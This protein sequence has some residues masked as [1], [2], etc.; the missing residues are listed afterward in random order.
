M[1]HVRRTPGGGLTKLP[2]FSYSL[3]M[4]NSSCAILAALLGASVVQAAD[5]G[6]TKW[7]Y[8]VTPYANNAFSADV[9]DESMSVF[10]SGATF[11]GFGP[12]SRGVF[13][14]FTSQAEYSRYDFDEP[15]SLFGSNAPDDGLFVELQPAGAVYV[16]E[17]L[18]FYAGLTLD[19]GSDLHAKLSDSL[20][21]G[22][23][24]GVNYQVAKDVW[25]GGGVGVISK[26]EDDPI[27]Y[28]LLN[29]DWCI[30]DKLKLDVSGLTGRLTYEL[31]DDWSIFAE[32]SFELRQYRFGSNG[33]VP[34]G[35]MADSYI[36]VGIGVSYTPCDTLTVSLSGGGIF[37]RQVEVF[38]D[39]D[40]SLAKLDGDTAV[41]AA[42]N[43]KWS[44]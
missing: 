11:R 44:F 30:T 10:R 16:N 5:E 23:F 12:V 15:S 7:A 14:S 4:R 35:A 29:I 41:Y 26:F 2:A 32:G 27:F 36:P 42:A 17:D 40:H 6:P 20:T 3:A 1:Q 37:S 33:V 25:I 19:Y 22:G 28:P 43:V 31:T 18:G 34:D 13:L 8:S 24:V 39:S 9:G 38:D 21:Y